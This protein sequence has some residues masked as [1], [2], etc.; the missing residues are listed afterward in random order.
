MK[1]WYRILNAFAAYSRNDVI[2][3]EG[4]NRESLQ[5]RGWITRHPVFIG[6]RKPTAEDIAA[7]AAAQAAPAPAPE[8]EPIDDI[9]DDEDD[10][11]IETAT[12][13]GEVIE[14]GITAES[15]VLTSTLTGTTPRRRGRHGR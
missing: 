12:L 10:V 4:L 3:P 11:L 6:P 15:A 7:W 13:T 8:P 9:R 2:C 14:S 1:K 5:V